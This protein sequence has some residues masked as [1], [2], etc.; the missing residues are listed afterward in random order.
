MFR[1]PVVPVPLSV[2]L[3]QAPSPWQN[4][5]A[6]SG[7]PADAAVPKS[8][9]Q[10]TQVFAP[11][12]NG[13]VPAQCA[14]DDV[15]WTQ[16]PELVL[17]TGVPPPQTEVSTLQEAQ[18][19]VPT[20]HAGVLPV[21]ALRSTVVHCTHVFDALSQVAVPPVHWL[22][23]AVEHWTHWPALLQAGVPPRHCVV[24]D[25]LHAVHCPASGPDVLQAGAFANGHALPD[26]LKSVSHATHVLVV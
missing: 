6:V 16:E 4:G 11:L 9:L 12:Q 21:Q 3:V 25:V 18:V 19:C 15:H 5:F 24:L 26:E 1:Q 10:A 17:Q 2:H 8:P 22:V 23:F 13:V 14:V 7:Q 20:S